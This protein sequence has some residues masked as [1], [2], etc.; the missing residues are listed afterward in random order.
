MIGKTIFRSTLSCSNSFVFV[1][2]IGGVFLS[3]VWFFVWFGVFFTVCTIYTLILKALV[4]LKCKN[5]EILGV[6]VNLKVNY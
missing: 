5:H 4:T 6:F 1:Y 2:Y 3:L